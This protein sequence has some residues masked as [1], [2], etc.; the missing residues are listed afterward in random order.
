MLLVQEPHFENHSEALRRNTP[1]DETTYSSFKA[2]TTNFNCRQFFF[3]VFRVKPLDIR[4]MRSIERK[5]RV[6]KNVI[7]PK[8][9]YAFYS[10]KGRSSGRHYTHTETQKC[11]IQKKYFPLCQRVDIQLCIFSFTFSS[12]FSFQFKWHCLFSVIGERRNLI[13]ACDSK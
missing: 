9:K 5:H 7:F 4:N 6:N 2:L 10:L 1:Y 11:K 8:W 3:N 13:T 12:Y